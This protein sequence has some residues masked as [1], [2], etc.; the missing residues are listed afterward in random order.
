MNKRTNRSRSAAEALL[1]VRSGGARNFKTKFGR[2]TISGSCPSP[3]IVSR[4][5]ERSSKALERVGKTLTKP[6]VTIRPKKG[7]PRYSVADGETGVFIR[8]LNGRVERGRLVK[9][10]FQVID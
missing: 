7:V 9:G 2:V 1:T 10:V 4:N 6:G 3:D 5:I 8:R